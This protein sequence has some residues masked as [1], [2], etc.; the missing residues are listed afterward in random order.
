MKYRRDNL[1]RRRKRFPWCPGR[2]RFP[3]MEN[4]VLLPNRMAHEL[5]TVCFKVKPPDLEL[6][7]ALETHEDLRRSDVIRRAIRHYAEHLGVTPP[8][9]KPTKK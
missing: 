1:G 9:P 8:K 3:F 5:T 2:F 7:E 6:I 4:R